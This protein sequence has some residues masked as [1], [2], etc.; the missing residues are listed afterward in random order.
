LNN[1]KSPIILVV[2]LAI[3]VLLA[4]ASAFAQ[5]RGPTRDEIIKAN[6]S[7]PVYLDSCWTTSDSPGSTSSENLANRAEVDVGPGDGASTLAVVLINRGLSDIAGITG[8]LSLPADF[9]SYFLF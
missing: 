8:Y 7:G 4:P 3:V 5:E 1:N 9:G 6:Y 2:A